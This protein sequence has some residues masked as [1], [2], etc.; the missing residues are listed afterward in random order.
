M[1]KKGNDNDIIG[2]I[3]NEQKQERRSSGMVTYSIAAV[4]Y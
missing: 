2:V 1:A 3:E 4:L